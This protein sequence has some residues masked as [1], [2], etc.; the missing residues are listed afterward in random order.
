MVQ[1]LFRFCLSRTSL[2]TD[3]LR[4]NSFCHSQEIQKVRNL[5]SGIKFLSLLLQSNDYNLSKIANFPWS[6]P[7]YTPTPD[8]GALRLK[9]L[10][11]VKILVRSGIL[12]DPVNR[13][14]VLDPVK[15]PGPVGH[16]LKH[17]RFGALLTA[18]LLNEMRCAKVEEW[19]FLFF[20]RQLKH[21]SNRGNLHIMLESYLPMLIVTHLS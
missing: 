4:L 13:I 18:M 8:Y 21:R 9:K 2:F 17:N 15:N 7:L 19:P 20:N 1:L 3:S 10:N 6:V 5:F 16:L 11:F 12:S 14:K